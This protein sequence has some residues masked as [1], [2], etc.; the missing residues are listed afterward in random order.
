MESCA[1]FHSTSRFAVLPRS[2]F[3]KYAGKWQLGDA[4]GYT[5]TDKGDP[6]SSLALAFTGSAIYVHTPEVVRFM[7]SAAGILLILRNPDNC[8]I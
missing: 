3:I 8:C 6:V 2:P 4:N 5:I 7:T 1:R